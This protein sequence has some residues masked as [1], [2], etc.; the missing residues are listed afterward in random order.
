MIYE[1]YDGN[2]QPL[3]RLYISMIKVILHYNRYREIIENTINE[4]WSNVSE[5]YYDKYLNI[6]YVTGQPL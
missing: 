2:I 4:T 1:D 5:E 3:N 6:I